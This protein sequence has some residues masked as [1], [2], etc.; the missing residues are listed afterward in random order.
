[1]EED[2]N[3]KRRRQGCIENQDPVTSIDLDRILGNTGVF[4]DLKSDFGFKKVFGAPDAT[5]D[6][7]R[8]ISGIY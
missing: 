7:S 3:A 1:M 6:L 8:L 4:V 2:M 5:E